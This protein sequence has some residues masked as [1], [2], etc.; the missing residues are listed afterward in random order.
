MSAPALVNANA[1]HQ[2]EP[3]TSVNAIVG[4]AVTKIPSMTSAI[5][6]PNGAIHINAATT[7]STISQGGICSR[8]RR[9]AVDGD[10]M[11][12]SGSDCGSRISPSGGGGGRRRPRR[13]RIVAGKSHSYRSGVVLLLLLETKKPDAARVKR[14]PA[15]GGTDAPF[16]VREPQVRFQGEA[17]MNRQARLAGS[18]K[19][20]PK[21]SS[22]SAWQRAGQFGAKIGPGKNEGSR[23]LP[24]VGTHYLGYCCYRLRRGVS[25][26]ARPIS[27]NL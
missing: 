27:T 26:L 20:D 22:T 7:S 10:R 1:D 21:R 9:C 12:R 3:A 25:A 14:R 23:R 24:C 11:C 18:V 16:A 17:D 4:C 6:A 8:R 15:L 5:T 19:N 13:G 2:H